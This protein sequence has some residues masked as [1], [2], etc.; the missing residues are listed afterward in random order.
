MLCLFNI[1]NLDLWL[2]WAMLINTTLCFCSMNASLQIL[3]F[4]SKVVQHTNLLTWVRFQSRPDLNNFKHMMHVPHTQAGKSVKQR[5]LPLCVSMNSQAKG[6]TPFLWHSSHSLCAFYSL[7]HNLGAVSI[8][9]THII[10]L[11][12]KG[13]NYREL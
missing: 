10:E 5:T 11:V 9:V 2:F 1:V 13:W 3:I 8:A 6:P 4:M 7:L 12:M